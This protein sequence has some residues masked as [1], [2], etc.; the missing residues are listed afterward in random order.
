MKPTKPTRPPSCSVCHEYAK[1]V[2]ELE[3][4]NKALQL[5][6][7]ELSHIDMGLEKK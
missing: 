1:Y 5:K 3:K 6:I 2:V 4:L 7:T